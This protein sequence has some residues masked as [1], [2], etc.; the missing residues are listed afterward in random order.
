MIMAKKTSGFLEHTLLAIVTLLRETV[1][2]DAIATRNG[3]LQQID[4]R[5][6]LLSVALL[7][8]SVMMTRSVFALLILYTFCLALT[9]LSRIS[10]FVF[11]KRTLLFI[12]LFSLFIALP[13]ILSPITPGDP[14]YT[15]ALF[16][17][18]ISITRQGIDSATIFCGRVLVSS[19][20]AIL[21]MLTTRHHVLLK[22]LRLFRIPQVFVM[23][24]TMSYRYIFVLLDIIYS[25]FTAIK[26]RVGPVSS[27]QS[28]RRI[29]ALN[30]AGLWLRSYRMH[31]HVY[32]AML[33][34][35]YC[36]E[37]V[38]LNEFRIRAGDYLLITFSLLS[39]IGTLWLNRFFH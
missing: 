28:G 10:L 3:V 21:L 2:S 32:D 37:P 38:V 30:M 8:T 17:H 25:T 31:T 29:V 15:F 36:G 1:A 4:P 34:R 39:L 26:S 22:V 14:V 24:M 16:S 6:K 11:L 9:V 5:F 13:A 23:T 12:P 18:A 27:T 7:L 20:F 19:S 35:G 33:S